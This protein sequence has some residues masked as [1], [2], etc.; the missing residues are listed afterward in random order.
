MKS[1]IFFLTLIMFANTANA[2]VGRIGA[3]GSTEYTAQA[4]DLKRQRSASPT[5]EQLAPQKQIYYNGA[6]NTYQ[7]SAAEVLKVE[8][9]N[10]ITDNDKKKNGSH[11]LSFGD[12]KEARNLLIVEAVAHYKLQDEKL[13]EQMESLQENAEYHR[14]LEQIMQNL[15]NKRLRNNKNKE[16]IRILNDAGNRLYN[17]LTN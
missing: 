10:K 16:A 8:E 2:Q 11:I 1:I 3:D 5:Y 4:Q 9:N 7:E 17:L 15:S 6:V 14:K 12:Q 13:S